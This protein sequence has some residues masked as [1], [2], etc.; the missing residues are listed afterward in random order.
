[1]PA[2][3]VEMG[4]ISNPE[5]ARLIADKNMQIKIVKGIVE[6]IKEYVKSKD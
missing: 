4:F 3:L 6:G 1:M 2:I 5:E